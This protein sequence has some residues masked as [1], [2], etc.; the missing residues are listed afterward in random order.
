MG[1]TLLLVKDL[2][3]ESFLR[4]YVTYSFLKSSRNLLDVTS[5]CRVQSLGYSRPILRRAC[6][7][8]LLWVSVLSEDCCWFHFDSLLY[9]PHL[10]SYKGPNSNFLPAFFDGQ[11]WTQTKDHSTASCLNMNC[12]ISWTDPVI[13]Q[14]NFKKLPASHVTFW[15]S[16]WQLEG[17]VP[18]SCPTP[19]WGPTRCRHGWHCLV[20]RFWRVS[21]HRT[22]AV[23][24]AFLFSGRG[25]C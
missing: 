21:S 14:I 11:K 3:E 22:R 20:A 19:G 9:L 16:H 6:R 7:G 1:K 2:L 5:W 10:V 4:Q 24:K 13:F 25:L 18:A 8:S 12:L 15:W 23:S 17:Q